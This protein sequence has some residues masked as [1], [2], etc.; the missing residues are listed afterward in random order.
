MRIDKFQRRHD[1]AGFPVAVAKKFSQDRAGNFAAL[2]AYYG[3]F[4]IFPLL[5]VLVA[6]LGFAFHG[7]PSF[8]SHVIASAKN[9]F[10]ALSDYLTIGHLSGSGLA[11]GLGLAISLWAGLGVARTGQAAMNSI[12]DVPVVNRPSFWVGRLRGLGL[13][14]TLGTALII[15]TGL[16][17]VRG[18]HG[19]LSVFFGAIGLAGPLVINC[20]VFIV[21]F[22]VLTT[23]H[24][25]MRQVLP[26][27][28]IGGLAWTAF[29]YGGGYFVR[30]Q[31]A[32]ASHLYGTF[33]V[34]IG[35]LGWIHISSQMTLFAAEINV[36]RT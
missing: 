32:H 35:L 22:C 33:A 8:Q 7:D 5:L 14:A 16:S 6:I 26:G 28:V 30:H 24:L 2:L 21:S 3:F 10:P 25:T 27:A 18:I 12:W 15:S 29:Q 1:W 4:S 23:L 20:V 31:V 13:L 34:V 11:L 9:Q 19:P 36:V 17:A